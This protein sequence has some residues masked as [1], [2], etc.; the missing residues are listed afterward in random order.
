MGHLKRFYLHQTYIIFLPIV[1][2]HGHNGTM[3]MRQVRFSN[4]AD[5]LI[6]CSTLP[7]NLD[8]CLAAGRCNLTQPHV[9]NVVYFYTARAHDAALAE[10]HFI[11]S[12]ILFS[13]VR[14]SEAISRRSGRR[15]SPQGRELFS[16]PLGYYFPRKPQD[17]MQNFDVI[18]W[19]IFGRW[20]LRR[21]RY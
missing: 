7:D 20:H 14:S 13:S 12:G 17:L 21:A 15:Q 1:R 11:W 10:L 19:V 9:R 8:T 2:A 3:C 18:F 5:V 16:R 4:R 6:S